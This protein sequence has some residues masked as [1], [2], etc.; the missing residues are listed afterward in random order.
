MGWGGEWK[1]DTATQTPPP[2]WLQKKTKGGSRITS[3]RIHYHGNFE[4]IRFL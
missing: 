3:E 4:T 1:V 2:L